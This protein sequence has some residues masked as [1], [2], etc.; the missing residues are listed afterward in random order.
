MGGVEGGWRETGS[1]EGE[2]QASVGRQD[3]SDGEEIVL[4]GCDQF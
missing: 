4:N 1:G 2:K 3:R